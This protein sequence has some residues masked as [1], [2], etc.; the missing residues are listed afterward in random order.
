M[1]RKTIASIF[2]TALSAAAA[3]IGVQQL[4]QPFSAH[5]Q[6]PTSPLTGVTVLATGYGYPIGMTRRD[7]HGF[8]FINQQTGDIWVYLGEDLKAHYRVAALGE[9]LQEV[10]E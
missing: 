8:T 4:L 6:Q 3:T 7:V 5:A 1:E 10:K 9:K 2:V